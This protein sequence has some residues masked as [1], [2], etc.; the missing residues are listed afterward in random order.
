MLYS[1]YSLPLRKSVPKLPS[2][3]ISGLSFKAPFLQTHACLLHVGELCFTWLYSLLKSSLLSVLSLEQFSESMIL[4]NLI[5]ISTCLQKWV[6]SFLITL[7][8]VL[9][10]IQWPFPIIIFPGLSETMYFVFH[11]ILTVSSPSFALCCII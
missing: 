7:L 4:Y 1:P 11:L 6:I 3:I 10:Q 9:P 8:R 5:P 2:L